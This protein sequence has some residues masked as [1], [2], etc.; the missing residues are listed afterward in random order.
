MPVSVVGKALPTIGEQVRSNVTHQRTDTVIFHAA[1]E[2]IT[3]SNLPASSETKDLE[4]SE[5]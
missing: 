2:A 4:R 1:I 5:V 3:A